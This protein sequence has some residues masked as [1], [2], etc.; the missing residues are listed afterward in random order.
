MIKLYY[1]CAL[2]FFDMTVLEKK[3][4]NDGKMELIPHDQMKAHVHF[5]HM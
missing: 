4:Y 2:I 1:F 3:K 5:L